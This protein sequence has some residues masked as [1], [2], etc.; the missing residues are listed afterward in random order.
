MG[1]NLR[2]LLE[3]NWR[4][5]GNKEVLEVL[6][7]PGEQEVLGVLGVLGAASPRSAAQGCMQ[8]HTL[9]LTLI[10]CIY[11]QGNYI[12]YVSARVRYTLAW[13]LPTAWSPTHR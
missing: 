1:N 2:Q 10:P 3:N 8:I 7:V 4:N 6:G 5:W 13:S 12:P 11:M 9:N